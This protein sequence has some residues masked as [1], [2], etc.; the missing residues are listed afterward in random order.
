MIFRTAQAPSYC[1]NSGHTDCAC[2]CDD[3]ISP[4]MR[5][6]L[7]D[8]DDNLLNQEPVRLSAERNSYIKIFDDKCP[9]AMLK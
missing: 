7:T 1:C 8:L 4:Y 3:L 2:R 9:D 5:Y 6:I